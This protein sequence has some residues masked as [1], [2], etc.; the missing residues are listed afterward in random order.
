MK[1]KYN[2]ALALGGG[3]ARGLAHVGVLKALQRE[4]VKIDLIVGTS[5]GAIIGAM[6]AQ[7][8]DAYEVEERVISF[9][10][11]F[12]KDKGWIEALNTQREENKQS[13]LSE[14]SNYVQRRY[15]GLKAL[16]RISLEK[17]ES[18]YEPLKE[19]LDN[20]NIEDSQ[21]SFA[22]VSL[23]LV[24]GESAVL[25]EGPIVD[26]VY[27]S[28]AIEGVFPPLEH[29]G[30]CLSDGGPVNITPVEIA[31]KMD[32]RRVLA[33]DVHQKIQKIH[34]FANGLEV[35]MRADNIGLNRLRQIDLSLADIV[36]APSV[37]SIHWANFNKAKECIRRGEQ[38]GE[39]MMPSL[40]KMIKHKGW[41][42]QLKAGARLLF[43]DLSE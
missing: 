23:D 2:M 14:I 1:K 38:A 11:S 15:L 12:L 43:K 20:N 32:A 29:N 30:G 34:K 19:I 6:Y 42:A 7:T 40:K 35:I 41:F 18:L 10:E 36:I 28:A 24:T 25:T 26:A 17:K 21:I 22:A 3:G 27:A 31:R 9:L 8:G 37:G 33:V 16:T 13:L 5:M 39:M 4:N